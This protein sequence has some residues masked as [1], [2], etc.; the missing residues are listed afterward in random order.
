MSL[1]PLKITFNMDG[2]GV[3]YD[4][5]EP[6]HLDGLLA[7][8][9]CLYQTKGEPPLSDEVPFEPRLPLGKWNI[10]GQW[11]WMASAVLPEGEDKF[12]IQYYRKKFRQNRV[13]VTCGSPNIQS[14]HYREHNK[15]MTLL[16]NRKF[17]AY[18][19]GD[20]G[21]VHQILNKNIR[22]LGK[23][24]SAGKGRILDI[25]TE[26]IEN[27]YSLVMDGC[28]M[29]YLPKNDA[30]RKVRTRPP[31]WNIVDRCNCCDVGDEYVID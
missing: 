7:W 8:A 29:R 12:S 3:Y 2:T 31:Y 13:D 9:L 1:R 23:K 19:L 15:P 28:A 6:M 4:A 22:F 16:L 20:R 18:A 21:R 10:N 27:D 25:T 5:H 24:R 14:G 11:G 26:V 17:V 30:L